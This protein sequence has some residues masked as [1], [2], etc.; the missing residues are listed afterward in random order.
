MTEA[1]FEKLKEWQ[2]GMYGDGGEGASMLRHS[3]RPIGDQR[4]RV[5]MQEAFIAGWQRAKSDTAM[6]IR[7]LGMIR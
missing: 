1:K 6:I 7:G 3:E 4:V 2:D 5:L